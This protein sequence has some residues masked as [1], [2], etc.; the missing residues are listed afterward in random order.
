MEKQKYSRRN[1]I[2]LNSLTSLGVLTIGSSL[3]C[4]K[5]VISSQNAK[6][7]QEKISTIAGISLEQLSVK[8]RTELF[9]NFIPNMDKYAVDHEYGGV[10]CSLDV[11]SGELANKNK[12]AWFVG[13][14]MWV[15]SFLYNNLDKN[16]RYLEIAEKSK[17]LLLKLQPTDKSF[18]PARFTREGNPLS[19]PGDIYGSL[20]VAE[21]LFE[22]AKASGEKKYRD[23]AKEIIFDCVERYDRPD[24]NYDI[25]YLRGA[26]SIQ[27]PRVLGHWMIFLSLSTQMLKHEP[28]P[29][30]EKL[31]ARSVDAIM[32]HHVNKDYGLTNEYINHDF[33]LPD[34]EYAQFSVIGHGLETLAFVMFEAARTGDTGLF[35][36]AEAVFKRHVDVATDALYGGYFNS[37]QHVNNYTW[38][39]RKSLWCQQEVLNGTLFLIEHK[40]DEWAQRHFER[41][42]K[43]I[44]EKFF[45]K[46][47]KFWHSGGDRKMADPNLSLLEHYHHARQLMLGILSIERMIKRGGI[48]SGLFA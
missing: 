45:N 39:V 2:K 5:G 12:T 47:N 41:T 8:Y 35:N 28:D 9:D 43:Y 21:G 26:P 17:D 4:K 18:W 30:M 16:P 40:G 44:Y 32:N 22:Y 38:S 25:T 1:F 27:G 6:S 19:G 48:I 20:F 13:R 23:L 29:D 31:A 24:Y 34:N 37:L 33:S 10:M 36:T 15:Y 14:G 7:S 11:R 46:N 42:D 3:G